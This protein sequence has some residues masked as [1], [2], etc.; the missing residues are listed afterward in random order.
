MDAEPHF[1]MLK[2]EVFEAKWEKPK[3]RRLRAW[4]DA[5]IF[6]S[7]APGAPRDD[8]GHDADAAIESDGT[9]KELLDALDESDSDESHPPSRAVASAH[10]RSDARDSWGF[11]GSYLLIQTVSH[12]DTLFI[13]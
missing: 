12:T 4:A 8:L 6:G 13:R 1:N 3:M 2:I 9:L 11:T 7:Q 10:A 5:I